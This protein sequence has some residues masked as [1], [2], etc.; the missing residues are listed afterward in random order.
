MCSLLLYRL[1][2]NI[3]FGLAA[4]LWEAAPCSTL[5][6]VDENAGTESAVTTVS[7]RRFQSA[8]VLTVNE[9]LYC[10]VLLPAILLP[11]VLQSWCLAMVLSE[12]QPLGW[13]WSGGS[14]S[15]A[16]L[17]SGDGVVRTATLGLEMVRWVLLWF[18]SAAMGVAEL[19]SGDGVV[20]TAT[21]GLE[22][23]RWI[24]LWFLS[25]AIREFPRGKAVM[26]PSTTSSKVVNCC[27]LR[28]CSV[29]RF[30]SRSMHPMHTFNLVSRP[31]VPLDE[32]AAWCC[33]I[34]S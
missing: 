4:Y 7:S 5:P 17:V 34:S 3:L 12:L 2:A 29:G 9:L 8:A 28:S 16:D 23:V 15:V 30:S 21:L 24:L 14:I 13:R 22:M 6:A 11:W 33:T 32:T 26:W 20:R 19:V 1:L 27:F 31:V 18:L 25:A 10:S